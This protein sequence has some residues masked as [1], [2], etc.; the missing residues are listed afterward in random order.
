MSYWKM[1][2]NNLRRKLW[3]KTVVYGFLGVLA[4]LLGIFAEW[5]LPDEIPLDISRDAVANLLGI[6][7]SSML[8]VTTFSIGAMTTAFGS[9]SSGVTPRATALLQEDSVTQNVLS[10]FIGAFVFS[11][12]GTIVLTTGS[13]GER[14]RVVLL[15]SPSA[16]WR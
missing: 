15:S 3:W 7:S 2:L 13:Y 12:I 5:F 11:V 6:I 14:G 10:S 4:A 8:A 1:V 16:C 9:A